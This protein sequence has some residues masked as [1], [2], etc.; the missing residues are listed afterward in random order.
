MRT[1]RVG[2]VLSLALLFATVPA[3]PQSGP[4]FLTPQR[5]TNQEVLLRLSALAGAYYRVDVATTLPQWQPLVTLQSTGVNVHVDSGAPYA[6]PRFYRA[7]QLPP[8]GVFTGDHLTTTNGDVV[9]HPINHASLVM[10]WDGKTIYND[11]VGGATPYAGLPRAD[12]ILVSHSHGDHYHSATLDAVR[13]SGCVIL[14]PQAVYTSLST[15]LRGITTVLTNGSSTNLLGLTVD[16]I[17]AYN[18]NHSPGAGNGYVVTMGGKRVYFAGDT[19]N[20]PE[21]RALRDIDVA[22]LC[23]NLPFTM[24]VTDATN[25]VR[26]FRPKVVYPYHYRDQSGATTNAVSFKERLGTDL[27]IEVRLRKWY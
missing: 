25:A 10:T 11:P 13:G 3:L 21:M 18:G 27:G 2:F 14:A 5:L 26:A 19:G 23:M 20:I 8:S 7:E 17:P 24:S 6:N 9:F 1:I 4:Q 22:F 16:A 15:T 12:L